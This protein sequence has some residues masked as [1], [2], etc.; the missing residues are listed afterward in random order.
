[1]IVTMFNVIKILAPSL[2]QVIKLWFS[3]KIQKLV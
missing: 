2:I 1:M 3:E